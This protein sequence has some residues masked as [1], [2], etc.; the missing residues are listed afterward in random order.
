M[1]NIRSA[2][3]GLVLAATMSAACAHLHQ[4]EL[5]ATFVLVAVGGEPLPARTM[6]HPG[7]IVVSDTILLLSGN[8]GVQP[9]MEHRAVYATEQGERRVSRFSVD[10][11][12]SND[13]LRFIAPPCPQRPGIITECIFIPRHGRLRDNTLEITFDHPEF[14]SKVY[15]RIR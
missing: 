14:R 3:A 7:E 13:I 2:L 1:R 10:Y 12:R 9:R 5:P 4:E 6:T 15:Q 8:P 11:T